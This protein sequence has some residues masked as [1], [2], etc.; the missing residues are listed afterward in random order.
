MYSSLVI[1]R[2]SDKHDGNILTVPQDLP[3]CVVMM[4]VANLNCRPCT[5][6]TNN[7]PLVY[8]NGRVVHCCSIKLLIPNV[9][10]NVTCQ[11]VNRFVILVAS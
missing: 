9:C 2:S 3:A 4:T 7:S 11:C 5:V 10:R 6:A 8:T 1:A